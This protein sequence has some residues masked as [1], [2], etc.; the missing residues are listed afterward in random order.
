MSGEEQNVE[1]TV[2]FLSSDLFRMLSIQD[3]VAFFR[4]HT[5]FLCFIHHTPK[6]QQGIV[7]LRC[8]I[9]DPS[10]VGIPDKSNNCEDPSAQEYETDRPAQ[11]N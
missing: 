3:I 4:F 2:A 5:C 1:I 9:D 6:I 10:V 8:G 11:Q 7:P